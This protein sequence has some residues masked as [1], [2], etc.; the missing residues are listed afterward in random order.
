MWRNPMTAGELIQYLS[1]AIYALIF[2]L[3]TARAARRPLRANVD[4][5]LFFSVPALIILLS[6]AG[7]LGLIR[8]DQPVPN[9]I[10]VTLLLSI[11]YMLMRLVDDFAYVSK[12]LMRVAGGGLV[13]LVAATFV[14]HMPRPFA[15]SI[16]QLIYL[17][18][19]LAYTAIAFVRESTRTRGVTHRRMQAV[20]AGS[21]F[22]CLI[23]VISG[24]GLFIPSAAGLVGALANIAGLA[25][26][27]C[28]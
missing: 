16:L 18:S 23:F 10:S 17:L 13:L 24:L 1:W 27:V 5:A 19:F 11:C 4:I 12:W 21:I 2:V 15:L 3:V 22:L 26:A 8:M 20:A 6:V 25:S 28:Y 14:L 9:A 7:L